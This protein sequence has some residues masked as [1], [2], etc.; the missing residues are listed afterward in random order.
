VAI[1]LDTQALIWFSLANDRLGPRA[2]TAIETSAGDED[3]TYSA[4]SIWETTLLVAKK[5]LAF[6]IS[7]H[8]WRR[9]LLDLGYLELP[10]TGDIAIEADALAD[11]HKDPADRFLVA[12][13]RLRRM[14][15]VTSDEAILAWPGGLERIDA[16]L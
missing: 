5:R 9:Q 15:L 10:L 1:L 16:R 4:V 7:L 8:L 3:L 2:R 11:F 6:Q 12:T 13:A 14:T